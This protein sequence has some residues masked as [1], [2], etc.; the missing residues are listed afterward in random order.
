MVSVR[1]SVSAKNLR[2]TPVPLCRWIVQPKVKPRRF[3]LISIMKA[4]SIRTKQPFYV[5]LPRCSIIIWDSLAAILKLLCWSSTLRSRA[6]WMNFAVWLKKR[7]A[8][9]GQKCARRLHS[10]ERSLNLHWRKHWTSVKK[11]Q[12][13]GLTIRAQRNSLFHSL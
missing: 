1:R 6:R 3:C 7:R 13:T 2:M 10:M 4:L 8:S 12:I 9:P 5:F 11:M